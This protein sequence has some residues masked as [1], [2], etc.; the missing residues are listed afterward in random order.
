MEETME[1]NSADSKPRLQS[2]LSGRAI[3]RGH[4]HHV[5]HP[6]GADM[7]I[8]VFASETGGAYSLMETVLPPGAVV[9][10]HVHADEDENNYV[11]EGELLMTIGEQTFHATVGSYVVAPSGIVQTFRNPGTVPCRFLTTFTPGG[12][13]GFFKEVGELIARAA[14]QRPDPQAVKAL[15]QK[16]G[17]TYL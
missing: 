16:Y 3:H 6:S 14:P 4:G 8:K 10:L 1:D 15:Q 5:K 11:L 12:A 13:E 17:L 7:H 2:D 9:P